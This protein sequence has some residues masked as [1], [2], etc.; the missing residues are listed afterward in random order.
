MTIIPDLWVMALVFGIF[1]ILVYLLN[2][3]LYKPL[4]HFMDTREDSIRRDSEGIQENM[5]DV[6]ALQD[7]I[8][9]ILKNAKKEAAIIKNKA[10]ESAKK[11]AEIKIAQKR[12][13]LERKYNDFVV[14]LQNEKELLRTSLS[15]Q[16]PVFKQNLQAKLEKL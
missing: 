11:N 10:H 3:I 8:E 16:I 6:K 7:E 1:L 15:L 13:E 9:E 4:L 14:N 2:D 12:E 5:T